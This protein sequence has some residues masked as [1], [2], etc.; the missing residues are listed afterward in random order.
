[1]RNT[2]LNFNEATNITDTTRCLVFR[3]RAVESERAVFCGFYTLG[4][5]EGRLAQEA[6]EDGELR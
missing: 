3:V 4:R 2:D 6:F 5:V 1:M